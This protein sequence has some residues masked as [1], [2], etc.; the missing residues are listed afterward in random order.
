MTSDQKDEILGEID[1]VLTQRAFVPGVDLGKLRKSIDDR[2]DE[3]DK[4]E[5]PRQFAEIVNGAF[6][7]FGLSHMTLLPGRMHRR[8]GGGFSAQGFFR[9]GR[10]RGPSVSWPEDDAAVLRIPSF[11]LTYDPDQMAELMD[12]VK[13]AKYLVVDLRED[14]GGELD[15]MCQFLGLL[16]PSSAPLGTFVSKKMADDYAAQAG[17]SSDPV[18]IAKWA[19][20][21][22]HPIDSGVKPFAGKIAVLVDGHSASAAE[23]VADALRED[24]QS[25][26]VGAPTMG[27][28]LVSVFDR[29]SYGFRLQFPIGDYVSH[30]GIRLEGHPI[31]PDVRA[32]GDDA[33]D[34]ALSKLKS[35]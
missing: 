26:I 12:S 14:P 35:K 22:L 27:A 9:G 24:R 13:D 33:I 16:L 4:A 10:D 17:K 18:K 1:Q 31:T 34:A 3:L 32:T 8:W 28:V 25:P 11:E 7:S 21:E 23:I 6:S 30:D 2:K 29:L 15:N 19:H 20:D 5:T